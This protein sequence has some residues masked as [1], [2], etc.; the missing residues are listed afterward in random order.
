M[1]RPLMGAAFGVGV[2][3]G[4]GLA[5]AA[6]FDLSTQFQGVMLAIALAGIG[7]ALVA[8]AH[9]LGDSEETEDRHPVAS[10]PPVET[11]LDAQTRRSFL[12][13]MT[14]ALGALVV[15]LVAPLRSLG[16]NP[17]AE[18]RHTAWR[19]GVRLVDSDG[20]PIRAGQISTGGVVTVFPEGHIGDA[21]AQALLIRV[22][23]A[24]I[25]ARPGRE[26]WAPDG[27]LVLSKVCTHAG[28]PVGLYESQRQ[29]LLCPCH[30]STFDILDG[31]RPVFGP[32]ARPLPQLPVAIDSAGSLVATDDFPEPVGPGFWD[33]DR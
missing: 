20:N 9:R 23:P 26:D 24:A 18:L 11:L 32:A 17:T 13:G 27:H 12:R 28:C 2:V 10:E 4:L 1:R 7:I 8:F 22:D 6:I 3:G 25:E 14:A 33:R 29:Q 16:R 31:A 15:G 19:S 21:M 30:Q 5:A